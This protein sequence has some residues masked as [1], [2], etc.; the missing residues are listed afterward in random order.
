MI[1]ELGHWRR[2]CA[3]AVAAVALLA[4]LIAPTASATPVVASQPGLYSHTVTF[5]TGSGVVSVAVGDGRR[6]PAPPAAVR[7]GE[8]F[9]GWWTT[10]GG[11]PQP[12]DVATTPITADI[13]LTAHYRATGY[14]VDFMVPS[15]ASWDVLTSVVVDAGASLAGMGAAVDFPDGFV[16]SG[17]F[18]TGDWKTGAGLTLDWSAPITS[19]VTVYPVMAPG[20]MVWF[21]SGGSPVPPEAVATGGL[22][23]AP[24]SPPTRPGYTFD[25]WYADAA[26]AGSD[27]DGSVCTSAPYNFASPVT[28]SL[29]LHGRWVAKVV[30]YTVAYWLEKPNIVP[31]NYPAPQW[32]AGTATPPV[33]TGGKLSAAQ[34][35]DTTNYGFIAQDTLTALAGSTATAPATVSTTASAAVHASLDPGNNYPANPMLF[36][37]MAWADPPSAVAGDGS[38]V[39]NVY[40]VRHVIQLDFQVTGPVA[41]QTVTFDLPSGQQVFQGVASTNGA[42]LGTFSVVTKID[43]DMAALGVM[44]YALDPA[45]GERLITSVPASGAPTQVQRGWGP[46]STTGFATTTAGQ[47]ANADSYVD[48]RW[49][50]LARWAGYDT[51]WLGL[52]IN[53]VESLDQASAYVTVPDDQAQPALH[54]TQPIT[55]TPR[56]LVSTLYANNGTIIASPGLVMEPRT[57]IWYGQSTNDRQVTAA[58]PG[59]TSYVGYYQV[60]GAIGGANDFQ[61]DGT[62]FYQLNNSGNTN[63]AFRYVFYSRNSYALTFNTMGGSPLT[64]VPAIKYEAPLASYEPATPTRGD[65]IFMGWYLDSTFMQPFDFATA[66]MPPHDLT[67]FAKWLASPQTVRFFDSVSATTPLDALTAVVAEGTPV[68][69]PGPLPTRADGSTFSG[70]YLKD[71]VT[72][73][74]MPYVWSQPVEDDLDLYARWLPPLAPVGVQY[75]GDGNTAGTVPVDATAYLPGTVARLADGSALVEGA[76]AFVGWTVGDEPT[77]RYPGELVTVPAGG[78][79]LHAHYAAEPQ[80]VRVT[81]VENANRSTK[82]ARWSDAAGATAVWPNAADVGFA[83]AGYSFLGWSTDPFATTPDA[84]YAR[85]NQG[86]V[87]ED[88]ILYGVWIRVSSGGSPVVGASGA[89]LSVV[90]LAL[91]ALALLARRRLVQRPV[92]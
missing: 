27:T 33:M 16:P 50:Y 75:M 62:K 21:D 54:V 49:T 77:M 5:D 38:T 43:L 83:P 3:A 70:W 82:A 8:A 59:F 23:V 15:G 24:T 60:P 86:V 66:T 58:I 42:R 84:A 2:R 13:A 34:T 12:F 76:D 40:V 51:Q 47:L 10:V 88:L 7:P 89:A 9:D 69:D 80:T 68:A 46:Y 90:L 67:L 25:A 18:F 14:V 17:M 11:V 30:S 65:D 31:D 28:A 32:T 73:K 37:E 36:A 6:V 64:G 48:P 22:A 44:P 87:D 52:S 39:L 26:C 63:H 79:V 85:L 56:L 53:Y 91:S 55:P 71:A 20:H 19:D 35:A 45:T 81:F 72:G 78:L 41:T 29:T 74:L 57:V 1:G 92:G 4:T 61:W